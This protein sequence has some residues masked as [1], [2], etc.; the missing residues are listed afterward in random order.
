M[1]EGHSKKSNYQFGGILGRGGY[2]EVRSAVWNG[3]GSSKSPGGPIQVAVKVVSKS[4]VS[5]KANYLRILQAQERMRVWFMLRSTKAEG[6][7]A[8]GIGRPSS[9]MIGSSRLPSSTSS[10]SC[11][12]ASCSTTWSISRTPRWKP[13]RSSARSWTCSSTV[14]R[15]LPAG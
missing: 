3:Q 10:S 12:T 11:W 15:S 14:V 13:S 8:G 5:D 2:S 1:H 4:Y 9:C 6:R 7:R